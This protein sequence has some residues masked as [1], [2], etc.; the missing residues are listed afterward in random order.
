MIGKLK[1]KFFSRD[2]MASPLKV[3][4]VII[5]IIVAALLFEV[6]R[7]MIVL[8]GVEVNVEDATHRVIIQNYESDISQLREGGASAYTYDAGI[9]N[10]VENVTPYEIMSE[11]ENELNLVR[12]GSKYIS[13]AGAAKE[14]EISDA[15]VTVRNPGLLETAQYGVTGG[16]MS[17]LIEVKCTVYWHMP[18]NGLPGFTVTI[19]KEAGFINKF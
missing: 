11:L 18:F 6:I 1:K 17:A 5:I 10:F 4:I 2:G 12:D 16:K 9:E 15:A 7:L 3:V 14:F 8:R 13:Y 19:K